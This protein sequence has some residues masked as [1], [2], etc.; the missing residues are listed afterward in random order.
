VF[1][2]NLSSPQ[3]TE[4]IAESVLAYTYQCSF[5]LVLTINTLK[6]YKDSVTWYLKGVVKRELSSSE[7]RGSNIPF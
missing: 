3:C 5:V 1:L 7:E 4:K 6:D 2:Q